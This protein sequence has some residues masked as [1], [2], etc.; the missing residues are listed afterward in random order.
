MA[1]TPELH[2]SHVTQGRQ[3]V[4]DV[5]F[6]A[7]GNAWVVW[8]DESAGSS[9]IWLTRYDLAGNPVGLPLNVESNTYQ[10]NSAPSIAAAAD[11]RFVVAWSGRP[12]PGADIQIRARRFS[13]TGA[14]LG[15]ELRVDAVNSEYQGSAHVGVADDGRFTI[16]WS[17]EDADRIVLQRFT[18][19]GMKLGANTSVSPIDGETHYMPSIA[20]NGS[21]ASVVTWSRTLNSESDVLF[22]RYDA[23]GNKL[24]AMSGVTPAADDGQHYPAVAIHDDGSFAIAWQ[25]D[26]EDI[27]ARRFLST[28]LAQGSAFVAIDG[29]GV[30]HYS[31][32]I[33]LD[34][35]RN[36]SVSWMRF[37]QSPS[38]NGA[39]VRRYGSGTQPMA[40]AF[41]ADSSPGFEKYEPSLALDPT[42]RMFIAWTS[43]GQDG[44]EWGV[45]GRA[46]EGGFGPDSDGDGIPD[47]RD[48]CAAVY[49]PTQVDADRD[50]IGDA[51]QR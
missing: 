27:R 31:P 38:E 29:N 41:R 34:A 23:Q 47:S 19:T 6:D 7:S 17:Q 44:S 51:C 50:R 1:L 21:G 16:V 9:N 45:Y 20:M 2:I 37:S 12:Q 28:G 22:Q 4:G 33:A 49:N 5:A 8:T 10:F 24:G 14:K 43:N 11:G 25:Q 18:A 26:L 36:L 39:Y 46:Y 42:G 15:E 40:A 48:N 3:A 35:D 13:A 32:D 30:Y